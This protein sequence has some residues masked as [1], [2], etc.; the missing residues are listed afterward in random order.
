VLK[1]AENLPARGRKTEKHYFGLTLI[2]TNN[3]SLYFHL[4]MNFSS[5]MALKKILKDCFYIKGFS[6]C[7][8]TLPQ[9]MD[10]GF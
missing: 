6:Y 9:V 5:S 8:T 4:N 1:G 3:S 10:Y 7:G 2:F